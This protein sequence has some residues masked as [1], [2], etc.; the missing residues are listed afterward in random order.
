[1]KVFVTGADGFI[2]S[3]LV[4]ILIEKGY[5][6][7]ALVLYN[8]FGSKGWLDKIPENKKKNINIILGDIR[9]PSS[10]RD[11]MFP[12][13]SLFPIFFFLQE[14]SPTRI[15]LGIHMVFLIFGF[16]LFFIKL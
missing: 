2:G 8:S 11:A 4:E 13:L 15:L 6:V 10:F 5:E 14:P 3:H 9:D 7:T 12:F 16:N 1:M